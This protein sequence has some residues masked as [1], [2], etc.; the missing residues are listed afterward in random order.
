MYKIV[1][2]HA[3]DLDAV[4]LDP[5]RWNSTDIKG[6]LYENTLTVQHTIWRS[7]TPVIEQWR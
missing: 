6:I 4:I 3:W 2:V 1:K 7:L 5:P